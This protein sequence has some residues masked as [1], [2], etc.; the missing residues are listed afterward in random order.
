MTQFWS[1]VKFGVSLSTLV[2]FGETVNCSIIVQVPILE[3]TIGNR[4]KADNSDCQQ[5]K[6]SFRRNVKGSH[7]RNVERNTDKLD[8]EV[9][10]LCLPVSSKPLNVDCAKRMVSSF[11]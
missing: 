8:L 7:S 5:D 2:L 10:V 11:T 4:A 9:N 1:D 3:G 6:I